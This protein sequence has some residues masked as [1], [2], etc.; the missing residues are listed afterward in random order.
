MCASTCKIMLFF[1]SFLFGLFIN[2]KKSLHEITIDGWKYD[3]FLLKN[4]VKVHKH[5][6]GQN[7][8]DSNI[9]AT[10]DIDTAVAVTITD[11]V[12]L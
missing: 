3:V 12:F 2:G 9:L 4:Y 10:V 5:C 1:S 11:V 7:I 6:D 8:S